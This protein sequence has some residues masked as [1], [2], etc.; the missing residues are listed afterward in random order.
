MYSLESLSLKLRAV[1][2]FRFARLRVLG[3]CSPVRS[4]GVSGLA[5]LG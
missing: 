2:A 5:S 3:L 1:E 4:F